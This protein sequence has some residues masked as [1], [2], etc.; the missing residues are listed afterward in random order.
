M[1]VKLMKPEYWDGWMLLMPGG[2]LRGRETIED[3]DGWM[4]VDWA[5]EMTCTCWTN[6][7]SQHSRKWQMAR[8]GTALAVGAALQRTN[9]R[10]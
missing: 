9:Y 7:F 10:Y 5:S 1:S 2:E 3:G 6:T 8:L 4:H